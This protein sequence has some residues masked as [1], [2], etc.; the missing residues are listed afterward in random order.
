MRPKKMKKSLLSSIQSPRMLQPIVTW[1]S[2]STA[3]RLWWLA[4]YLSMG[5]RF[6]PCGWIEETLPCCLPII[7][8]LF[9]PSSGTFSASRCLFRKCLL[10]G[11]LTFS[12]K[13][14]MQ[15]NAWR[16][17]HQFFPDMCQLYRNTKFLLVLFPHGFSLTSLLVGESSV[18]IDSDWMPT[19][20]SLSPSQLFQ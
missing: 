2:S 14:F 7:P 5:H 20:D 1:A 3:C 19:Q 12:S 4:P 9:L 17:I 18:I 11:F 6:R 8:S 16:S 15:K 13:Q 10:G